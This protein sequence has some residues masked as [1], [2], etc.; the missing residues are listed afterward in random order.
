MNGQMHP[1]ANSQ[2]SID[3]SSRLHLTL[4]GMNADGYRINGGIGFCVNTP[5]ARVHVSEAKEFSVTDERR[6]PLQAIEQ[7]RLA[8]TIRNSTR[9]PVSVRIAG[10]MPSHFGFGSATGIRLAALE[11]VGLL[12]GASTDKHL[13]IKLSGRGGTSGIGISTYFDGGLVFDVGVRNKGSTLLPSSVIEKRRLSPLELV[14]FPMPFWKVGICIPTNIL[15]KSEEEEIEFFK[16]ACHLANSEVNETLY[17][18]VYGLLA[19]AKEGDFDTFCSA[20]KAVQKCKW[21]S[22]ERSLYGEKLASLEQAI[23][24]AGASAVGMSSLGPG[25][26]Y[27]CENVELVTSRLATLLQNEIW[28]TSDCCNHGRIIVP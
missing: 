17:H 3:V 2:V 26:F 28:L 20:V 18:V 11:A 10:D 19:S 1:K 6:W 21:K 9:L 7:S 16:S 5:K 23:Y 24:R 13:L 12:A 22:M 25:L 27:L 8:H 14:H 15:Q 4:I